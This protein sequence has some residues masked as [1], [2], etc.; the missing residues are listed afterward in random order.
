MRPVIYLRILSP[1]KNIFRF[2]KSLFKKDED[3]VQVDSVQYKTQEISL[4]E[5]IAK[6]ELQLRYLNSQ[7]QNISQVQEDIMSAIANQTMVYEEILSVLE[8]DSAVNPQQI[9]NKPSK[10]NA[11]RTIERILFIP[12]QGKY[13]KQ[14]F[15]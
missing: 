4:S 15:N 6:I 9:S 1:V 10:Q 13:K 2:I 3:H 5:Q 12:Y 11:D 7:I 14:T 8:Q